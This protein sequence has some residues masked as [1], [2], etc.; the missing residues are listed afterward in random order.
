MDFSKTQHKHNKMQDAQFSEM[1]H[2]QGLV[3][4]EHSS[5]DARKLFFAM[6]QLGHKQPIAQRQD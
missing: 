6:R 3:K 5:R 2:I 4:V 1:P